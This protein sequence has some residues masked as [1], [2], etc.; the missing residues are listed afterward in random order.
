M[1]GALDTAGAYVKYPLLRILVVI[2]PGIKSPHVSIFKMYITVHLRQW[3][4]STSLH[5]GR[6]N[7]WEVSVS[8]K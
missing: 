3:T 7:E 6:S 4:K 2:V 1:E 8:Q 5:E